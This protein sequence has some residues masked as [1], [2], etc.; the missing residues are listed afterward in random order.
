M[1]TNAPMLF[2]NRVDE[3]DGRRRASTPD[4]SDGERRDPFR[5]AI[6]LRPSKNVQYKKVENDVCK[7]RLLERLGRQIAEILNKKRQSL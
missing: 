4:G 3:G 7:S 5:V 6:V 1:E 2:S